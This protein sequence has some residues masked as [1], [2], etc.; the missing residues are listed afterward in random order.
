[1]KHKDAHLLSPFYF[2][3]GVPV[4]N[5]ELK[6]SFP[7]DM[8]IKY[9]IR[10]NG[11]ERVTFKEE[12]KRGEKIYTF[13]ASDMEAERAYG[14]APSHSWYSLHVIFYIENY[15]N[16]KGELVR[17]LGNIDDLYKLNY[18]FI[19][20]LNKETKPVLRELVDSLTRN[21]SSPEQKARNIYRWVQESVKYVAFEEGMEGFIPRDANLVCTR[22]FGDCKDMA[23]IL[24]LMLNTAGIPAFY[25]WIGTRHLPYRYEEVPTPIVDNHMICTILLDGKYI[26]LD[27]TDATCVFGLPAEHIQGKEAL[28]SIDENNYKVLTVP[29]PAKTVNVLTDSTYLEL[30]A[31]GLKGSVV[32]ARRGYY[33]MNMNASLN[34]T[35]DRDLERL[36]KNVFNRGS[37]KFNLSKYNEP[38]KNDFEEIKVSGDF[39]LPDY[40]RKAG[41]DIFINM[42]LFK[43]YLNEEID[44]PKRNMPI[45]F[46]FL[47]VRNY[48]TVFKIPAGYKVSY[49]PASKSFHN[50][51]WGFDLNYEQKGDSIILTQ[52]FSNDHMMLMPD[53]FQEWNKV[54]ES[55]FPLYKESVNLTKM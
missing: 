26:F 46:S 51:I 8:N 44:F 32:Q 5:S 45:E 18:S 38:V 13:T 43:H 36:M 35:I 29:V 21:V 55:L 25:T 1:M 28:L 33:A 22:R 7:K 41:D 31:E 11:K 54:L 50:K 42:N 40:A 23:S 14:D 2:S 34:Y 52:T 3:R 10:G 19:K 15:K 53:Q 37:N 48:V 49:L 30:A 20:D 24:T 27:G 9:V 12:T 6:I 39:L 16:E 4:L 47:F 17:Y